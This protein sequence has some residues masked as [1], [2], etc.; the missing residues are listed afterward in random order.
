M[1]TLLIMKSKIIY[2][3]SVA[4]TSTGHYIVKLSFTSRNMGISMNFT[5]HQFARLECQHRRAPE[6]HRAYHEFMRDYVGRGYM[7]PLFHLPPIAK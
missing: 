7:E 5:S 4:R 3:F 2:A 6:Q 1:G